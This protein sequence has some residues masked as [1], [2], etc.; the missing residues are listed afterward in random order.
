[1]KHTMAGT[2]ELSN[3]SAYWNVQSS[4][5]ALSSGRH[6]LGHVS[7][8]YLKYRNYTIRE[9]WLELCEFLFA[10]SLVVELLTDHSER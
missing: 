2:N 8:P 3:D 4:E 6:L 9:S 5:K 1:M 10:N 7:V